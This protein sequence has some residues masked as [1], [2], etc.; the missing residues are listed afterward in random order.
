MSIVLAWMLY[1]EGWSIEV[2]DTSIGDS[3]DTHEVGNSGDRL[4][5]PVTVKGISMNLKSHNPGDRPSMPVTVLRLSGEGS[6]PQAQKPCS[7]S[8]RDLKEFE[9]GPSFKAFSTKEGKC[10]IFGAKTHEVPKLC[11][12]G[13]PKMPLQCACVIREHVFC[14]VF[15]HCMMPF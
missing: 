9:V 4:S 10:F 13:S 3:R 15:Y 11:E 14:V 6:L 5:M 7:Y 2:L 12:E 1:T 8:E